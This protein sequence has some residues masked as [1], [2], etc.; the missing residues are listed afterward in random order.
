M[1]FLGRI[2]ETQAGWSVLALRLSL[3]VVFFREGAGKLYG[4]FDGSGWASTCVYFRNLG[5][6][7]PEV[8]AFFVGYTEFLG[9]IALCL[10]FLTRLSSFLIGSTMAVAILTAHLASG[11]WH[12]P[13]TILSSCI[14]LIFLGGGHLS[15]DQRIA[16]IRALS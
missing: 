1:R 7:F 5:I 3:G 13:L 4:W 11:G 16:K 12:Y 15:I 8:N 14:V 9:G 10:G 2:T 6:P